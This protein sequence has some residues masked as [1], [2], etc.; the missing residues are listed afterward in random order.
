MRENF[1]LMSSLAGETRLHPGKRVEKLLRFNQRLHKVPAI[2]E[3]L[4]HW[5]LQLDTKLLEIPARELNSEKIIF[6]KFGN[7]PN[8]ITPEK[9]D[10]TKPMHN[11]K[12]I[13]APPLHNW[14]FMITERDKSLAQ[15]I[16]YYYTHI[17]TNY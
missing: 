12:C 2:R 4:S 7:S 17:H 13:I 14:V 8:F 6:G 5:N 11:K 9:G 10:W 15:V 16:E 1:R 3:D